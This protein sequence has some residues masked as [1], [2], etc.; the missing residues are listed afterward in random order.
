MGE[1]KPVTG[2]AANAAWLAVAALLLLAAG[3]IAHRGR[4][5]LRARFSPGTAGR[6]EGPRQEGPRSMG[7]RLAVHGPAARARL[8]PPFAAAGVPYPPAR[9][10][11][12]GIK[13]EKVLHLCA[14][15][16][17]C[18]F[19]FV[20]SYPILGASGRPGPKLRDGDR[21]VPEGIYGIESLNPNS[22]YHLSLRIGYPN[23]FDRR[24]AA[25]D[26][27]T[28]LGGDIMIHGGEGSAGCLAMGDE[29]AEDL[30]VLAADAGI[31]NVRIVIAP[32]DFRKE[33]APADLPV[34]PPWVAG[35]Y[36]EIREEIARYPPTGGR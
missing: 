15:G 25:R 29:A 1:T 10:A 3:A 12:I 17:G 7:D 11:L 27:R 2:R 14:A 32:V 24:M 4:S 34:D 16:R 19:A 35:L 13:S 9:V 31:G 6:G 23:A 20:R 8:A 5:P 26:G 28:S 21:Q 33:A 36:G 18:D 22:L 30:F